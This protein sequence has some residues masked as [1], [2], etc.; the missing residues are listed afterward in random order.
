MPSLSLQLQTGLLNGLGSAVPSSPPGVEASVSSRT[1]CTFRE[2]P[3][4][5]LLIFFPPSPPPLLFISLFVSAAVPLLSPRP[6]PPLSWPSFP[7]GPDRASRGALRHPFPGDDRPTRYAPPPSRPSPNGAPRTLSQ[8]ISSAHSDL[9]P[10]RARARIAPAAS[11][12]PR[13]NRRAV[14]ARAV[15]RRCWFNSRAPPNERAPVS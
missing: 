13:E 3:P 1:V 4:P 5:P 9:A 7:G 6:P 2:H 15:A 14:R 12:S 10:S 8:A 11:D